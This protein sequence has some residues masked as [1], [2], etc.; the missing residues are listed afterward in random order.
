MYELK[1]SKGL[2]Y[3]VK[4]GQSAADISR[5][6]GI[7]ISED[8]REGQIIAVPAGRFKIYSAKPGDSFASV[9]AAFGAEAEELEKLNGGAVYPT[10]RLF[11]PI[12]AS[13][14]EDQNQP[15]FI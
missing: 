11:V 1:I 6:L 8:V 3:R 13:S 9:A 5:G 15:P 12:S 2:F 7:P 4:K 10:R 14:D